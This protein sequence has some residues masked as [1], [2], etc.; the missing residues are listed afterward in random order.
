M[1]FLTHSNDAID[2]EIAADVAHFSLTYV[3]RTFIFRQV[4]SQIFSVSNGSSASQNSRAEEPRQCLRRDEE[5]RGLQTSQERN[6]KDEK[7]NRQSLSHNRFVEVF[8][9]D[10][11]ES[12]S[13][14]DGDPGE[15]QHGPCQLPKQDL[16]DKGRSERLEQST[17]LQSKI[18]SG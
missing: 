17:R 3:Q 1:F 14:T 5:G 13:G 4:R 7:E 12:S 18:L 9:A 8:P 15:S 16:A 6:E 10:E 2:K 11:V